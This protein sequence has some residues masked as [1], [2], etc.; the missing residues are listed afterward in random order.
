MNHQQDAQLND[1]HKICR[2]SRNPIFIID[3]AIPTIYDI[4][5]L[6]AF[7]EQ[8]QTTHYQTKWLVE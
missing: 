3:T 6:I 2:G 7:A 5:K 8:N 4:R 1:T